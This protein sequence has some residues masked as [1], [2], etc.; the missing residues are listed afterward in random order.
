[1]N[2][3]LRERHEPRDPTGRLR[4]HKGG[5]AAI[6]GSFADDVRAGL[7]ARP[8]R[9]SPMYLYDALGSALFEAICLLPEYYLT[10]AETEILER[11]AGA[12]LDAVG[13]P[14]ELV[15]LGSGSS[16]KTRLLIAEALR[17]QP[18]LTYHPIDISETALVAAARGLT[19]DFA[20]LHIAAHADDYFHVLAG[21]GL[22]TTGR[23]LALFMGSNIG[24][25]EPARAAELLSALS[26]ALQPGDGV[27]LGADMKKDARTLESAY[28][29]ATGV[30]AAF[31]K[32]LL[33]RINRELGGTFDLRAF[34]HVAH[35]D[36]RKGSVDSF[37]ASKWPQTVRIAA[38][39]MEVRFDGGESIHTESSY[40]FSPDDVER[41]GTRAGLAVRGRWTDSAERFGVWLLIKP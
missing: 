1:V 34:K 2:T 13:G 10:R 27:L 23:V 7:S 20:G 22:A 11:D 39:D 24:N 41:I 29:D 3:T 33:G 14:V 31:N 30:T 19:S 36:E 17:R 26:A 25:Y 12:I 18:A 5:E 16:G 32:N 15:E 8:K 28:D 4:L 9:L 21:G 6:T 35:Y 38:L 40:K 37:L